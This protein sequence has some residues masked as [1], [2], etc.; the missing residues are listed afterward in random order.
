MQ[1]KRFLSVTYSG[2]NVKKGCRIL[3]LEREACLCHNLHL[4]V[5]HDLIEKHRALQPVRDLIARM[6]QVKKAILFRYEEL[7]KINDDEHNKRLF[8]LVSTLQNIC[9]RIN[10]ISRH[11][12]KFKVFFIFASADIL[13]CSHNQF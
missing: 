6:K 12:L 11:S 10:C 4:L 8:H 7:K 9:K 1:N 13:K 3:G 2:G 5:A